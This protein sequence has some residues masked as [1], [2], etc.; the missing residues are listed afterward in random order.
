MDYL[1]P[2]ML[3]HPVQSFTVLEQAPEPIYGYD[4]GPLSSD[5]G[6]STSTVCLHHCTVL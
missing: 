2:Y 4:E 1:R 5:G 3:A 6:T